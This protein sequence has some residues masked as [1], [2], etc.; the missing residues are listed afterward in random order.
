MLPSWFGYAV[1]DQE[2]TEQWVCPAVNWIC[3]SNQSRPD[4]NLSHWWLWSFDSLGDI[5]YRNYFKA[6]HVCEQA[7]QCIT[8]QLYTDK[9][10]IPKLFLSGESRGQQFWPH[11]TQIITPQETFASEGKLDHTPVKNAAVYAFRDEE[12]QDLNYQHSI[13][14]AAAWMSSGQLSWYLKDATTAPSWGDVLYSCA[15]RTD[16][17]APLR[18][19]RK[20]LLCYVMY[21]H[22]CWYFTPGSFSYL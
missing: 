1:K 12:H 17:W 20:L 14:T 3:E 6:W 19:I 15:F 13:T 5:V 10:F 22:R 7:G 18:Y 9:R 8:L 11:V 21:V 4:I 16:F 2:Q